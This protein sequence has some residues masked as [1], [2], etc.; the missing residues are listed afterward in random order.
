[1]RTNRDLYRFIVR[2]IEKRKESGVSLES[3]LVAFQDLV[4]RRGPAVWG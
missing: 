3:Y 1:M 2:L 4:R